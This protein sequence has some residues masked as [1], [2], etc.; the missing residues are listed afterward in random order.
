MLDHPFYQ[1][2]KKNIQSTKNYVCIGLDPDIDKMPLHFEKSMIGLE[3]FLFEIIDNTS[4]LCIAYKPNISFFEAY[5]I[6]GL[7]LLKK[8]IKRIPDTTPSI[9]DGKRG[10]IGNTSGKQAAYVYDYFQADA[11]TLHPY[12]GL[13]SLEPF[14][15]Y[16]D[17]FNFVLALTSNPSASDFEKKLMSDN[18]PLYEV[19]SD[20]CKEWNAVYKNIGL[21]V[22]G[23]QKEME[24]IRKRDPLIVFLIPGVGAQ[25]GNYTDAVENGNNSEKVSIINMSRSIM[26]GSDKT[27]YIDEMRANIASFSLHLDPK[28]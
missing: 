18:R 11:T 21:V 16:K 20:Q 1:K 27:T 3:K 5:G 14:F 8:V 10:D 4:D 9:L 23:T 17:K 24:Q 12:M 19:V 28:T 22:G 6:D 2:I 7:S 25:G 15:E 26:Y 13:D